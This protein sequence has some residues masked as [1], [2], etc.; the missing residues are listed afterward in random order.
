MQAQMGG[1]PGSGATPQISRQKCKEV[2]FD[3]EERKFDSMRK[4]M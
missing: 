3:S 1:A 4:M 2:F